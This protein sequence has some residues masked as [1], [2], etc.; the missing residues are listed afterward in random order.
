[1][2]Q[3]LFFFFG[4][5]ICSFIVVL[6]CDSWFLL[7]FGLE[8]NMISFIAVI[9]SR[10]LMSIEGCMKYFFI[11]SV[12]S[13]MLMCS[14][15]FD[16][17]GMINFVSFILSYKMGAG[18]F[19]FW[20]SSI[21]ES[22]NWVSCFL[23]MTFQKV[24]PLLLISMFMGMV[25]WFIILVSIVVG[26]MG[27]FNEKKLKKLLAFS[28][29]HH[30]GWMMMCNYLGSFIWIF[31]WFG[32]L[33]MLL[34]LVIL[35]SSS[36]SLEVNDLL[37]V[38]NKLILI[39]SMLNMGGIPPMF[40]FF[41][42]WFVFYLLW[43]YMNMYLMIMIIMSVFMLYI[44]LRMVYSILVGGLFF[45]YEDEKVFLSM[46]NLMSGVFLMMSILLGLVILIF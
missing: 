5:Y 29:I 6:G 32:Y 9:Y 44:Y 4:I 24:M 14:L 40:G 35:F 41:L 11:Q 18:P 7:W 10:S 13:G 26:V 30:M 25:V 20:F 19:F 46:K 36:M 12:G 37:L 23:L 22:L 3:S 42:K 1:M 16:Y 33:F 17:S 28:S 21:C 34:G 31:Y 45:C 27:A 15:Y 43:G 8:V 2:P 38:D 39:L